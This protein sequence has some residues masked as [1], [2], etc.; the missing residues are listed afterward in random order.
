MKER[1]PRP[2]PEEIHIGD[3]VESLIDGGGIGMKQG[4]EKFVFG[5]QHWDAVEGKH[6]EINYIQV[7]NEG[8]TIIQ[9]PAEF[10]R[11]K[12]KRNNTGT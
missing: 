11:V 5:V 1:E 2:I 10:F 9:M 8:I 7:L 12:I 6:P 4:E 3:I